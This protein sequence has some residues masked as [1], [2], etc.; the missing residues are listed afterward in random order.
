[1]G[2][3]LVVDHLEVYMKGYI[4]IK[5]GFL[6]ARKGSWRFFQ[7]LYMLITGWGQSPVQPSIFTNKFREVN[8]Q[9]SVDPCFEG[10]IASIR[11]NWWH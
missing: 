9:Y 6:M 5:L 8:E 11:R 2:W 7:N 4:P 1:M 10:W 3:S